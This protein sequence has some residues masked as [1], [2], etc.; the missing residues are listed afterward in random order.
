MPDG[1]S[2]DDV[3]VR[4]LAALREIAAR[5]VGESISVISH[6]VVVETLIAHALGVPIEELWL[7]HRG[8]NCFVS[9]LDVF[10]RSINPRVIYDGCHVEDLAGLDGTKGERDPGDAKAVG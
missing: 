6:H 1:E 5:H 10:P 9:M 2:V 3:Q 7:P 8:G 4:G